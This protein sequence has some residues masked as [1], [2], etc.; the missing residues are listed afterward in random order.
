MKKLLLMAALGVVFV[1]TVSVFAQEN[2]PTDSFDPVARCEALI[3]RSQV[4]YDANEIRHA[5]NLERLNGSIAKLEEFIEKASELGIITSALATDIETLK[6][7]SSELDVDQQVVQDNLVSMIQS[8][9]QDV[10]A[11]Q[12]QENIAYANSLFETLRGD[13]G[14]IHELRLIVKTHVDEIVSE[15]KSTPSS[16]SENAS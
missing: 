14:S 7:Y 3:E 11:E 8:N 2:S 4:R 1:P 6:G 15:V 16:E 5:D 10:T 9:C 12:Y 13:V